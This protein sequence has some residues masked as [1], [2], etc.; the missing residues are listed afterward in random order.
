[1]RTWN[2]I[3]IKSWQH[4]NR[5]MK[6]EDHELLRWI[7]I[8]PDLEGVTK[9]HVRAMPMLEFGKLIAEWKEVFAKPIT[10]TLKKEWKHGGK[11]YVCNPDL[12]R[13][14]AGQFIDAS[15]VGK[16]ESLHDYHKFL[17]I[18]WHE[19]G[20]G[21]DPEGFE[22][23]CEYIREHMPMSIAYP[24]SAHFFQVWIESLPAIQ[25]YLKTREA[26]LTGLLS[27]G[28]GTPP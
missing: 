5:V 7:D 1:M 28:T 4:I 6:D 20:K 2:D 9:E 3:T 17:A 8:L 16:G 26:Q 22:D 13:I 12:R 19:K 14:K 23:R 25:S 18:W 11:T 24:V 15:V 27:D 10:A 21:Y